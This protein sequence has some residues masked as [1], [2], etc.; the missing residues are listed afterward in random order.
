LELNLSNGIA[1]YGRLSDLLG[2]A[3]VSFNREV[4]WFD[5]KLDASGAAGAA[6][7]GSFVSLIC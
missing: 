1:V 3:L 7:G 6:S 5:S 2:L 4:D